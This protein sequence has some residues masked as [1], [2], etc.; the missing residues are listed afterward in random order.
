MIKEASSYWGLLT[1]EKLSYTN[2]LLPLNELKMMSRDYRF[3]H[4]D[5]QLIWSELQEQ[6]IV[7]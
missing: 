3:L 5:E 7:G 4:E 1:S 2:S 6:E